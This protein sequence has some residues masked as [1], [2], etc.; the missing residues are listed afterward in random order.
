MRIRPAASTP[1]L[2]LLAFSGLL[3]GGCASQR[4]VDLE[5]PERLVGQGSDVHLDAQVVMGELSADAPLSIT[6]EI[7]N[8]RSESIAFADLVP[9]VS[10]DSESRTVTVI[11]GS[12]VPGNDFVPK[13]ELIRSGE[14]RTFSTGVRLNAVRP[15]GRSMPAFLRIRLNFLQDTEPFEALIG[16]PEKAL[17]DP[18]LADRLFVPWVDANRAVM[19]NDIPLRWLA[20]VGPAEPPGRLRRNG[21]TGRS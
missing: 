18:D 13:L 15:T 11:L 6:Y 20:S 12:E 21:G 3:L 2:T 17:Y 10:Y 9:V 7:E 5:R 4:G 8:Q 14:R 1:L 16:I 19:T